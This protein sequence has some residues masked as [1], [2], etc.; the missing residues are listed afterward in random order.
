LGGKKK[1]AERRTDGGMDMK[2]SPETEIFIVVRR[3]KS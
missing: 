1:G 2:K 3:E